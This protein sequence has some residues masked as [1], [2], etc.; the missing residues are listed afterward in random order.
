MCALPP[1][2][3]GHPLSPVDQEPRLDER[4]ETSSDGDHREHERPELRLSGDFVGVWEGEGVQ[5]LT[6]HPGWQKQSDTIVSL[7][8]SDS[9]GFESKN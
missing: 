3:P 6:E 5:D 9:G 8:H 2:L 4:E 7:R 1:H